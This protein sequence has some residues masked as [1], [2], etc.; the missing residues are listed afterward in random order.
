[1]WPSSPTPAGLRKCWRL[2]RVT[3]ARTA[4]CCLERATS[5]SSANEPAPMCCVRISCCRVP[6]SQPR[7]RRCRACRSSTAS[8]NTVPPAAC[9]PSGAVSC[10]RAES[11]GRA[12]DALLR[13]VIEYSY[14][15]YALPRLNAARK[16]HVL[17]E[18][19]SVHE[20]F[21]RAARVLMLSHRAFDFEAEDLPSNV[22]YIGAPTED[23]ESSGRQSPWPQNDRRPLVLV[24]LSTLRQGQMDVMQRILTAVA[25]L[26]VRVLV[27]VFSLA[28]SGPCPPRSEG[29]T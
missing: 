4:G 23:C 9:R 28:D 3:W 12:R 29:H 11:M 18:L 13:S 26:P 10:R 19:S 1:M 25:D 8:T 15:R 5:A 16:Q 20:Q 2:P 7:P 14:R 6:S 24:S 22:R 27:T 21:D 17:A